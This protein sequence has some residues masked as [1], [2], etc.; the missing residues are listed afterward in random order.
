MFVLVGTGSDCI[1]VQYCAARKGIPQFF[2]R[3]GT[4]R[5]SATVVQ[6]YAARVRNLSCSGTLGVR[7]FLRR[8]K[9]GAL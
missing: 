1:F 9:D 4:L 2:S 3:G 6:R 7:N 8:D 5:A